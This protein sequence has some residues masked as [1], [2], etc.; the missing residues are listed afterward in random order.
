MREKTEERDTESEWAE[1]ER[2]REHR[3][4]REM[5]EQEACLRTKVVVSA[6]CNEV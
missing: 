4:P 1:S 5:A 6:W 2:E 3:E